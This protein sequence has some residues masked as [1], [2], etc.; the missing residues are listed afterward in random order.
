MDV[1]IPTPPPFLRCPPV[2]PGAFVR[3]GWE[4]HAGSCG[5]RTPQQHL[6]R[7]FFFLMDE[8]LSRHVIRQR[9]VDFCEK[10]LAG[11]AL[12]F[13]SLWRWKLGT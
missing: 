4:Y 12:A 8:D 13:S 7:E 9:T 1:L 10:R 5:A 3:R 11:E 2:Y 6:H